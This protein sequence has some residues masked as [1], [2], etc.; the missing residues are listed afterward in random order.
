MA[1]ME[2]V[3]TANQE[4]LIHP[5]YMP[6]TRRELTGHFA[7]SNNPL[8]K[9]QPLLESVA[10]YEKLNITHP[11]RRGMSIESQRKNA[12][13][14][15]DEK[16]WTASCLMN[17][18]HHKDRV[19]KFIHLLERTFG[20]TPPIDSFD[21]WKQ[22]LNGSLSLFFELYLPAPTEYK[23]RLERT[24]VNQ[25]PIPYVRFAAQ[26]P[27]GTSRKDLEKATVVDAIL[28]NE[29]NGFAVII[30]AKVLS[31]ISCQV[32]Y[33]V[34]RNQIARNIDVMLETNPKLKWPLHRRDSDK[35]C[36]ML[37]T[38]EVFR[39]KPH[40]RLYGWLMNEYMEV[41][42]AIARDLKHRHNI[43]WKAVSHRLGWLTWED[44]HQ[45]LHEACPWLDGYA[46]R[47]DC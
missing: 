12:Q 28:I 7:Q 1:E 42:E 46:R 8:K 38:P 44:C 32:S 25:H 21:D 39:N 45:I 4:A 22:A 36:F 5:V 3:K 2:I 33:D 6:F 27:N 37:L 13:I 16:F 18:F 40:T 30:E 17:F 31:D 26:K 10:R 14:E 29:D 34:T 35:T 11:D 47:E 20:E 15:K 41:P 24:V 43:D 19:E 23:S 9:V